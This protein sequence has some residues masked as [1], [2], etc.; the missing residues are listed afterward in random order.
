MKRKNILLIGVLSSVAVFASA[1]GRSPTGSYT[2][3]VSR[4]SSGLSQAL[5]FQASISLN[6]NNRQVTGTYTESGSTSGSGYPP[7]SGSITGTEVANDRMQLTLTTGTSSANG[8]YNTGYGYN[9]G[10]YGYGYTGMPN[11]AVTAGTG[12]CSTGGTFTGTV[13]MRSQGSGKVLTGTLS[14]T[15][16]AGCTG[17]ITLGS[18]VSPN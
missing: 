14:M 13:E 17:S 9:T 3:M 16:P 2:G 18:M 11:A 1:C 10:S 12:N 6:V 8:F 5:Q 15:G 4:T 7:I